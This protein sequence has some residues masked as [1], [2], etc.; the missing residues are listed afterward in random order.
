MALKTHRV[1]GRGGEIQLRRVMEMS[2][3]V[4]YC[5]FVEQEAASITAVEF[6][7]T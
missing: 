1:R 6:A 5:D 7:Q 3:M 4:Q 2:G